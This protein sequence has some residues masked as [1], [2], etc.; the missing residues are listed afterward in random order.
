MSNKIKDICDTLEDTIKL[1]YD[2]DFNIKNLLKKHFGSGETYIDYSKKIDY[3]PHF[4]L[5]DDSEII[6]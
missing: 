2:T 4:M 1:N 6:D 3:A 5:H